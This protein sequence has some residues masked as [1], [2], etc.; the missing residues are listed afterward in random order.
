MAPGAPAAAR[1]KAA[2]TKAIPAASAAHR[3]PPQ[4][5]WAELHAAAPP[6]PTSTTKSRSDQAIV[7]PAKAGV[8]GERRACDPGFA[9]MTDE[10]RRSA[11]SLGAPAKDPAN[12]TRQQDNRD[13]RP[14]ILDYRRGN[15]RALANHHDDRAYDQHN[16]DQPFC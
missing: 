16:D 7:T 1:W 6:T 2:T 11:L 4:P 9:G 12:S 5:R 14:R 13:R 3:G 10:G 15:P 8:Q